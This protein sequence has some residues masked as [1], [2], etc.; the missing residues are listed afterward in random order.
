MEVLGG[1][2][3]ADCF[4]GIICFETLNPRL[5]PTDNTDGIENDS[6]SSNQ[7][8]L[9]KPSLKAFETAIRLANVDPKK[10]VMCF[11][12]LNYLRKFSLFYFSNKVLSFC[13]LQIF[14]DDSARNIATGKAAGLHTVIVS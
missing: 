11:P 8:I 6:F 7:R 5:Q 1:L 12:F 2:G 14:F 4:E 3:L 9:C 10:T 13:F